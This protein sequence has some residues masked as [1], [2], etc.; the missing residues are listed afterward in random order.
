MIDH[1]AILNWKD[2]GVRYDRGFFLGSEGPHGAHKRE[3]DGWP[4]SIYKR[5]NQR[6]VGDNVLCHGIQSLADAEILLAI[7]NARA[8]DLEEVIVLGGTTLH[9][10]KYQQDTRVGVPRD[11]A[12]EMVDQGVA[13][14]VRRK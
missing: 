12:A 11:Q 9:G 6:G 10:I 3:T 5:G 13:F 1:N 7:L 8:E 2:D 4:Y 14:Y